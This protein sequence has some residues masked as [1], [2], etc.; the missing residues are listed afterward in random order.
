MS[1]AQAYLILELM[2]LSF[3]VNMGMSLNMIMS[4]NMG[5]NMSMTMSMVMSM[6]MSMNINMTMNMNRNK[7]MIPQTTPEPLKRKTN[8]HN[9]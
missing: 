6:V 1:T 8:N 2:E 5:M 4:L 3:Y 9:P 7:V